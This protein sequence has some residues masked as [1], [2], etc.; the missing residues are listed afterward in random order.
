MSP[1]LEAV[2]RKAWGER[3][4]DDKIAV[5]EQALRAVAESPE[6]LSDDKVVHSNLAWAFNK[7]ASALSPPSPA[8][9]EE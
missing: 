1:E 7:L 6:A 3:A 5:L 2:L 9:G 4:F 8:D